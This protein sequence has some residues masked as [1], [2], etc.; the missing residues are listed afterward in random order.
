MDNLQISDLIKNVFKPDKFYSVPISKT[1]GMSFLYKWFD[2]YSWLCYSPSLD[3]AFCLPCVS[4]GDRFPTK[5]STIKKLFSEPITH[6]IF[7]SK[8]P[9]KCRKCHFRDPYFKHFPG[10]NAP[11]PP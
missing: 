4:F 1:N 9:P 2:N 8:C 10:D 7:Y 6:F 11:G 3:G 5:A